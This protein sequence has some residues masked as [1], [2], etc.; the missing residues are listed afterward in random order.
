MTS[1]GFFVVS[2]ILQLPAEWTPV[3]CLESRTKAMCI[4]GACCLRLHLLQ[5]HLDNSTLGYHKSEQKC[6]FPPV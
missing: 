1:T 4:S 5:Q 3:F 6:N 2:L